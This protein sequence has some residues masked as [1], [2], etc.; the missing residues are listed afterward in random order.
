MR[1]PFR[2]YLKHPQEA[3]QCRAL[4]QISMVRLFASAAQVPHLGR[5]GARELIR[6]PVPGRTCAPQASRAGE[7][8]TRVQASPPMVRAGGRWARARR[9]AGKSVS[10]PSGPTEYLWAA[11]GVDG[12]RRPRLP[13]PAGSAVPSGP[14]GGPAHAE[15]GPRD[16]N[17][18]ARQ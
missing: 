2:A 13:G 10:A 6:C 18:R 15:W 17:L 9:G 11:A 1:S 14:G 3:C 12:G 16:P 7:A 4:L 5:A 8:K